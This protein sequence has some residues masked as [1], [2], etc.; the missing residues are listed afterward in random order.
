MPQRFR[1][2]PP[3]MLLCIAAAACTGRDT[4]A[5]I[6]RLSARVDSL[7]VTVTAM[8]TVLQAGANSPDG[9]TI[10]VSDIGAASL[11]V[12]TAPVTVIEFTDYQCPFCAQHSKTTFR[13][14][15]QQFVDPGV[16]RYVVRDLPLGMHPL[17]EKA[18]H[19]ARCA[20]QQGK[21]KY[22]RYH[23]E[24]FE[25][26]ASLTGTSFAE[27]ATETGLN[28]GSFEK[29]LRSEEIAALVRRDAEEAGNAGLTGTPS[30]VV[31][32]ATGGKVT[33]VVI[34]G[35]FPLPDFRRAIEGALRRHSDVV[36]AG[37]PTPLG[38]RNP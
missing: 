20:G 1:R 33:G 13:A 30:F 21:D 15:Q 3:A 34:G 18:A 25:S 29:C 28:A 5:E 26:Q 2:L 8:N 6:A 10:T 22:W 9:D 14:I 12:E 17:A 37:A 31:G 38:G 24:L 19:A 36:S 23:D 16:V 7:A 11:G 27:I 32:S 4:R 35:A